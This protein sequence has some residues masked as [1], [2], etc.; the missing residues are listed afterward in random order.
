MQLDCQTC[1]ACCY[2]PEEYVSVNGADLCRFDVQSTARYVVRK[3]ERVFLRMLHG[4]CAALRAR[5]GHFGC[6]IYAMRPTP[7][8]VVEPGGRECLDARRRRGIATVS[9]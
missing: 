9:A 5:Q 6:R 4:H 1:G 7:C 3:K 8:R 2:G